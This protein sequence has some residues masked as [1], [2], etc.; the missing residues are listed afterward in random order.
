MPFSP[1]EN[2]PGP[3]GAEEMILM[4]RLRKPIQAALPCLCAFILMGIYAL[5]LLP[6]LNLTAVNLICLFLAD[7]KLFL[8]TV[9]AIN[10]RKAEQFGSSLI[11]ALAALAVNLR[12]QLPPS[13]SALSMWETLWGGL[14]AVSTFC[15]AVVLVRLMRWSQENWEQE[16]KEVQER[17]RIR[18]ENWRNWWKAWRQYWTGR[19]AAR[20]EYSLDRVKARREYKRR[21]EE[22]RRANKLKWKKF[23]QIKKWLKKILK[24]QEWQQICQDLNTEPATQTN[25]PPGD[26]EQSQETTGVNRPYVLRTVPGWG[27]AII[28]VV[29]IEVVC[30]IAALLLWIPTVYGLSEKVVGWFQAVRAMVIPL[31]TIKANQE[32][33]TTVP[34][35]IGTGMAVIY[36]LMIV[37]LCAIIFV[38]AVYL[39]ATLLKR[40]WTGTLSN[41]DKKGKSNGFPL[42]AAYANSFALLLVSFIALYALSSGKFNFGKL[43]EGW[44]VLFFTVLFILMILTAFEIVRLVLEQCGQADSVLKRIIYLFFIAI[45]DLLSEIIFG[46]LKS[47]HIE[48][49]VSSLLMLVLPGEP[50]EIPAQALEK[51]KRIF[52]NQISAVQEAIEDFENTDEY[53]TGGSSFVGNAKP[54]RKSAR[55][56]RFFR[57]K[58]WRKG[59]QK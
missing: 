40:L 46:V 55:R 29:S 25:P 53:T 51:I 38:V 4:I 54:E 34:E 7:L 36:Y 26:T 32:A 43:T 37:T 12:G 49:A 24:V 22:I 59:K 44:S 13:L 45:L 20:R 3:P 39:I 9:E 52:Q 11:I 28:I 58:V 41:N 33:D 30:G 15:L 42:L 50:D 57:R 10:T 8:G 17:R 1:H 16:R 47:L 23:R 2:T 18:R 6:R 14:A 27:W 56:N 5:E 35:E 19:M 31:M 21:V 48:N